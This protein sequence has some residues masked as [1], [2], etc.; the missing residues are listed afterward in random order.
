MNAQVLKIP[1]ILTIEYIAAVEAS[2]TNAFAM[3]ASGE[4]AHGRFHRADSSGR[5]QVGDPMPKANHHDRSDSTPDPCSVC[6]STP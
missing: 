6:L 2:C 4:F 5:E 1:H 3:D